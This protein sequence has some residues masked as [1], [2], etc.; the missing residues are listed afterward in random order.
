MLLANMTVAKKLY[1][2]F[3]KT[4][5]LRIHKDPSKYSLNTVCDILQKFG[6]HLN[7]ETAKSLQDSIRHYENPENNATTVNSPMKY[8]MMVIINLCSK[9]MMVRV[10][11]INIFYIISMYSAHIFFLCKQEERIYNL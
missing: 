5:L 7:G 3:P 1:T 6:I 10:F 4:A 8:I 11:H 2:V 9:T